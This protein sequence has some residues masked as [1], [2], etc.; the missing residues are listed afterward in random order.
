VLIFSL[1]PASDR[2]G[3]RLLLESPPRAVHEIIAF[4][5]GNT[6]V[7][8]ELLYGLG[9]WNLPELFLDQLGLPDRHEPSIEVHLEWRLLATFFVVRH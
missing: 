8:Q 1:R 4:V 7:F 9:L 5:A 6:S 2:D 3:C